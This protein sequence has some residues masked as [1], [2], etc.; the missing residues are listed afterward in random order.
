M[1]YFLSIIIRTKN[2]SLN[3]VKTLSSIFNQHIDMAFE[4]IVI[5]SGSTDGTLELVKDYDVKMLMIPEESFTFGY[6]LNFGIRHSMGN[7]ICCISAHCLPADNLWL[8]KITR[9]ILEKECQATYGRQLPIKKVNPFEEFS[10][11]KHFP[12]GEKKS[13]RIP[14]SNANCAFL[15]ELWEE[16]KF[17]ESIPSWEDYL[18]YYLLKKK[19]IFKYVPDACVYHSHPFSISRLKRIAYQDGMSFRYM[20][21]RYGINI[22]DDSFSASKFFYVLKDLL[23]HGKFFLKQRYYKFFLTYPIIRTVSYFNY[24][25]GYNVNLKT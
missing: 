7:I 1:S 21:E 16:V 22:L 3:I 14:F 5:D 12:E 20:R 25:K 23:N 8:Y 18:W 6:S 15:K 9:P 2:E 17:D 10:F 19:Y 24:W 11:Y 4:V 13:G